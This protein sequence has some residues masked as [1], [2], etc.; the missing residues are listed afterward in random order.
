M[1]SIF[2]MLNALFW[3]TLR[4]VYSTLTEEEISR[5]TRGESLL[6]AGRTHSVTVSLHETFYTS[7]VQINASDALL[8]TELSADLIYGM[9]GLI[10]SDT[11][12]HWLNRAVPPPYASLPTLVVNNALSVCYKDPFFPVSA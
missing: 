3:Q 1:K 12:C 7:E 10:A 6:F 2:L 11:N 9:A 5:N 8:W 4:T